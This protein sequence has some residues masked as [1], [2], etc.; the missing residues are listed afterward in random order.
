MKRLLKLNCMP[1]TGEDNTL[2]STNFRKI[3]EKKQAI[4][5]VSKRTRFQSMVQTKNEKTL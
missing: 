4:E 5:P 1:S 2:E 3:P